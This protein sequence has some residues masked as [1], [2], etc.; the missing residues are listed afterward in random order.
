MN[1][2]IP[3]ARLVDKYEEMFAAKTKNFREL[4]EFLGTIGHLSRWSQAVCIVEYFHEKQKQI[5]AELVSSQIQRL[6]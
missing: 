2:K 4:E 6:R 3:R 1:E 5:S